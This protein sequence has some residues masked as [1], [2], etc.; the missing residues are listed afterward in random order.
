[1]QKL[2]TRYEQ[3]PLQIVTKIL[4]EEL[5]QETLPAKIRL[6]KNATLDGPIAPVRAAGKTGRRS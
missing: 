6:L 3:V 1:M 4:E 5:R 2:K